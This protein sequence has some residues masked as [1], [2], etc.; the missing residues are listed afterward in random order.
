[1]KRC[2]RP[3]PG[4]RTRPARARDRAPAASGR[5]AFLRSCPAGL[6]LALWLALAACGDPAASQPDPAAHTPSPPTSTA[7]DP[8]AGRQPVTS[9]PQLSLPAPRI[10]PVLHE[11]GEP[12]N[13]HWIEGQDAAESNAV[14]H[15][16]YNSVRRDELSGGDWLSH[17]HAQPAEARFR[18]SIDADGSYDFWLRANPVGGPRLDYRLNDGDWTE[19]DFSEPVQNI[20][21]AAD[22]QP[23]LR[24]V[25][26]LRQPPLELAAGEHQLSFRFHSDN[27]NHGGID[28]IVLSLEPF[29]P[30]LNL[31]PGRPSGRADEGTWAFEPEPHAPDAAAMLDL[32]YLNHRP[33]GAHGFIGTS[34]QGDS[35]VDGR[36]Q[37]IRFWSGTS[38][39]AANDTPVDEIARVAEFYARLGI[40]MVRYHGNLSPSGDAPFDQVN[41][42]ALDEI[43]RLVAGMKQAG[44][45]VT[46][47]PYWASAT[48]HRGHWDVADPDHENMTGLLFFDPATQAGY[49]SWLRELFTRPNPYTDIALKDEP[50]VAMFQIQNE[51]SLLFW[52]SQRI[53]GRALEL[54]Q[55][56]FAEWLRERHGSLD[57]AFESWDNDRH[58]HDD[59]DAGRVGL[60]QVW[61]LTQPPPRQAGRARRLADQLHFMAD[62]QHRF[63]H[64]IATFL[65]EEIGAPQLINAG[66]WK[67][68]DDTRLLDAERWSYSA[69]EVIGVNKY[70]SVTHHGERAGHAI[71]VGD[72]YQ[73]RSALTEPHQ[74]PVN[75]KQPA[76][77]PFII[78]ESQWVPP[79]PYQAEG[80]LAVAA[81]SSLTGVD[82]FYWFTI[83][84][85]FAPPFGKWSTSTP[86][87]MGMF[88]AA[89]LMFRNH[90]LRQGEPVLHEHRRLDDM[91]A[92]R[93]SLLVEEPGFDPNRDAGD[94]PEGLPVSR[95]IDP[96]AFLV[97]PVLV[98]YDSDP[99]LTTAAD[100]SDYIDHDDGVVRANTGEIDLDHRHG[101][102]TVDAPKAQAAAGFLNRTGPINLTDVQINAG[103]DYAAVQVVSLDTLDLAE[104]RH[105][106][107]QAATVA[108]PHGFEEKPASWSRDDRGFEGF[109]I[110]NL[111]SS[112]WN[113][114]LND[115]QLTI[116]NPH[117]DSAHVLDA[118]GRAVKRLDFERDADSGALLLSFPPDALHV[119]LSGP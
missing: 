84:R 12:E 53:G 86:V 115:I 112:P 119:I 96:M 7:P 10:E 39:V 75:A 11:P 28:A 85:D 97:G 83:E 108:R 66:N 116:A 23:D 22:G 101:V 5:R 104:S 77:H 40:N 42:Q 45:Y 63:H 60:H 38:Y 100:L 30:N 50:A 105:I 8:A 57:A 91:F 109:E 78:P 69:N 46:I 93:S 90:Y 92:R 20:N 95:G 14:R 41:E 24:F 65:R 106:L 52:T 61:H 58:E 103:N 87:Q 107:V 80:P 110:T 33:A 15:G 31:R 37:P 51:D 114:P 81:Y 113:L 21:I 72:R 59:R 88:P 1:M 73:P 26:W 62:T 17:F 16:W 19:V 48:R 67:T 44:I 43:W 68:A 82:S 111:G 13:F 54:W 6:T 99:A 47:S 79:N 49:K 94:L 32:R 55:T 3:P 56:K 76:G 71:L 35:F 117:I 9:E 36:G 89:A 74:L 4:Y 29:T 18:L 118:N 34:E 70:F 25:A 98:S 64:M 102:L 27:Q 2:H